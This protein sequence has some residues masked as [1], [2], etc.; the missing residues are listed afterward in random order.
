MPGLAPALGVFRA[1]DAIAV[2]AELRMHQKRAACRHLKQPERLF[3]WYGG[4]AMKGAL[5]V[6]LALCALG[7]LQVIHAN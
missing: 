4:H 6:L 2:D 1:F 5:P 7:V 3:V